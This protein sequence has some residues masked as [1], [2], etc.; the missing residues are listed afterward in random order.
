MT[1]RPADFGEFHAEE[2]S[3][4]PPPAMYDQEPPGSVD[5]LRHG[6]GESTK[7]PRIIVPPPPPPPTHD[8]SNGYKD[9]GQSSW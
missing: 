1:T 2:A 7:P 8:V 5:P 3:S 4:H 6:D 9:E